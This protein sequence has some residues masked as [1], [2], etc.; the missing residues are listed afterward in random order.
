LF[1]DNDLV[2]VD[3]A[4]CVGDPFEQGETGVFEECRHIEPA[5]FPHLEAAPWRRN[6]VG[7]DLKGSVKPGV[8]LIPGLEP[9]LPSGGF[10]LVEE[11]TRDPAMVKK[12][13]AGALFMS[14]VKT[15]REIEP[16]R[17][18]VGEVEA[19]PGDR[20]HQPRGHLGGSLR[21]IPVDH[22]HPLPRLEEVPGEKRAGKALT[23]NEKIGFHR[24]ELWRAITSL[25]RR[26]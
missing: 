8:A 14:P 1:G 11:K 24:E 25:G 2:G 19:C 23:D 4:D 7:V 21:L 10:G 15:P 18:T 12:A 6:P 26:E 22:Q 3:P 20:G 16:F 5:A 17:E 13:L 9:L